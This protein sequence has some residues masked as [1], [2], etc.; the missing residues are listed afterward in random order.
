MRGEIWHGDSL[1]LGH[2]LP[3][4][5]N[6]VIADPPYGV[7]FWSR[8]AEMPEGKKFVRKVENDENLY[9][10]L[11][12]F[13]AVMD[14]VLPKTAEL[15]ELYVFTRWDIVDKWIAFCRTHLA[16]HNFKYKML[17]VYDKGIPGMGDIDSNW[18]CG[19]E[20]I[21]YFKKGLREVPYRRSGIIAVNRVHAS[22]HIHPTEKPVPLLE[23]L[24]EMSTDPGD[25]VV[26]PFSGSG[27][28]VVAAQ[29]LG[30]RGIGIELDEHYIERSR[31]RVRAISILDLA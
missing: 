31:E 26:D 19:H 25:L 16:N 10:A 24:I 22:Q 28:T 11:T 14:V 3:E 7:N 13:G 9:D 20:L 6:C 8:R 17:L 12:L 15:A 23:K 5:I 21:L 1:V 30:R 4:G 2:N 18:G 29:R 27:S